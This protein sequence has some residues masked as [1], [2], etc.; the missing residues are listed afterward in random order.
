MRL[1]IYQLGELVGIFFLLASTATQI[2]YVEPLR[3]E[4]EWRLAAFNMQQNAQLQM[5]AIFDS[6]V[7]TLRALGAPAGEIASTESESKQIVDR[8]KTA[9]ANISDYLMAKEPVE[10]WL[11]I[12]VVVLF[13]IGSLLAGISRAMD[14]LAGRRVE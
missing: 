10:N 14:M 8:Y 7:A 1:K 4:I 3:R 12:G 2:F 5:K 6:R 11:Q 13:A 9:D